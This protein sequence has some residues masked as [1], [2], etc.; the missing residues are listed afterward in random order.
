MSVGIDFMSG[1]S[2][3]KP[4]K[5]MILEG[6]PRRNGN[7]AILAREVAAGARSLGAEVE[8]LCL[9]EMEIRPCSA[10]DA[11]QES[12]DA[13]CVIED[14]MKPV[15]PRLW[16]ADALVFAGPVYWFTVSAQTKLFMDRCYALLYM[17]EQPDAD[18]EETCIVESGFAGKKIGIVLTYGDRDPFASGAVN[19]LRAFQDMFRFAGGEIVDM[20]YGSAMAP[21]EIAENGDLLKQAFN[22]G[23]SLASNP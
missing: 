15:Y 21:G 2:A 1:R 11:C 8:T 13:V 17:K 23:R 12:R 5:I 22:L 10:C 9:H 18:G 20:V 14:D 6:S 19:A 16:D 3:M 4:R 7:S